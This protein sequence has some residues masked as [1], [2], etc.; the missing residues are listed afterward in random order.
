MSRGRSGRGGGVHTTPKP[1]G[2]GWLNQAGGRVISEHR[3]KSRAVEAGRQAA[4]DRQ[5]EHTIH[6]AD[7]K[8]GEKNS[9]GNDPPKRK[10]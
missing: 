4:K 3:L 5:A 1:S 6:N 7:G 10:G 2:S 9:Y 8:I